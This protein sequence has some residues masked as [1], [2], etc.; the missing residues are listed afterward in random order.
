MN[1]SW[2]ELEG[3]CTCSTYIHVLLYHVLP[4]LILAAYVVHLEEH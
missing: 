1:V 2:L 3:T 4:R